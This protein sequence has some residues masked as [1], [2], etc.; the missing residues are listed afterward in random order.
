MHLVSATAGRT[1]TASLKRFRVSQIPDTE[2]WRVGRAGC[3]SVHSHRCRHRCARAPPSVCVN[4]DGR[5]SMVPGATGV[6][7]ECTGG[8]CPPVVDR[9]DAF[10][11]LS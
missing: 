6:E 7:G 1:D 2:T 5:E 8:P 10:Q 4:R 9:N 11:P 3:S